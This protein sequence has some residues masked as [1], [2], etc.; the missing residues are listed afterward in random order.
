MPNRL[1][2]LQ[3]YSPAKLQW[4][5]R[6][7]TAH[8]A[9]SFYRGSLED[10]SAVQDWI[11]LHLGGQVQLVFF[12]PPKETLGGKMIGMNQVKTWEVLDHL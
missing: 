6:D 12:Q 3:V 8:P 9:V 4:G 1:R 7:S 11:S 10:E 5:G 2:I